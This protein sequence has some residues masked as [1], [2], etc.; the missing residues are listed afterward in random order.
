MCAISLQSHAVRY[1]RTATLIY[2][3]TKLTN[4]IAQMKNKERIK[5]RERL[6]PFGPESLVASFAF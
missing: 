5:F 4:K 2:W 1:N 6:L 3:R